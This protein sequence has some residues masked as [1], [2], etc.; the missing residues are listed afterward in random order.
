[1][2][3]PPLGVA[4]H[5]CGSLANRVSH[6]PRGVLPW[7]V[8]SHFTLL[9]TLFPGV[10]HCGV[11]G[12]LYFQRPLSQRL[13]SRQRDSL[14][15]VE[16]C[17]ECWLREPVVWLR[18]LTPAPRTFYVRRGRVTSGAPHCQ[19]SGGGALLRGAGVIDPPTGIRPSSPGTPGHQTVW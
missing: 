10:H 2:V 12:H 3:V 5:L 17:E 8:M 7:V 16:A 18:F 11:G 4:D 1:M 15:L 14:G 9:A 19:K 6:H 13:L